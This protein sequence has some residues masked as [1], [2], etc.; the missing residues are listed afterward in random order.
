MKKLVLL[1]FFLIAAHIAFAQLSKNATVSTDSI[2]KQIPAKVFTQFVHTALKP[3]AV[4]TEYAKNKKMILK[5]IENATP[6]ILAQKITTV[7]SFIKP[8]MLKK[9]FNKTAFDN[10]ATTAVTMVSVVALL[11]ELEAGLKADALENIWSFQKKAWLSD[12]S[13]VE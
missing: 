3:T 12:I 1:P 4:T 7:L 13:K 8:E 5:N 2:L 11:K 6:G 10:S 9:E